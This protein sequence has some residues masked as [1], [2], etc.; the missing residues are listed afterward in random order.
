MYD[1]RWGDDP[2][3]RDDQSRDLSR[4]SRGASDPRERERAEPRDVF[5]EHVNLP[6]GPEREHVRFRDRDYTLRSSESRVLASVGA[7]R[8]I[9]AD[10]LRDSFDKP[11]D[12]RRG[13]LWHLRESGLVHTVRLD[14][15]RTVVTLTKE[16]HDLLDARR[17]EHDARERQAFH[18]GVQRPRELKHDAEVYRAYLEEA[19]RLHEMGAHIHRVVLEN[20]LKAEYQEFLQERNRDRGDSD[21]RPDRDPL[22]IQDWATEHDLPCDDKDHVQFP[23]VRIEYDIDGRDETLDVE[24]MTRHYRGAHA[25]AKFGSG[26]SLYFSGRSRSGGGGGATPSIIEEF[27]R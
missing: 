15:D 10:D 22:E 4:G 16:G 9:P 1:P 26:F 14:R 20:E 2:R 12:P 5:R 21:G 23:G 8:V 25:A 6:R 13:E 27:L 3:E 18:E 11:L 24:V 7:F 17:Q 19:E